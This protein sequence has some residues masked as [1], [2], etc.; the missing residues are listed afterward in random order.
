MHIAI[1]EM[2]K[3]VSSIPHGDFSYL[4]S[5]RHSLEGLGRGAEN[6]K[7]VFSS[8]YP[9]GTASCMRFKALFYALLRPQ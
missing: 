3:G 8:E 4:F 9:A 6:Q 7:Q 2:N 5:L 1:P